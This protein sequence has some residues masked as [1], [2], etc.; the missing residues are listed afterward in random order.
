MTSEDLSDG[1]MLFNFQARYKHEFKEVLDHQKW[2]FDSLADCL[3]SVPHLIELI[4]I[5]KTFKLMPNKNPIE[6]EVCPNAH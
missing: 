4:E 1:M 2:G 3:K 5:G 6:P